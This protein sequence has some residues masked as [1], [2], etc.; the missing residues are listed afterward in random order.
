M[1]VVPV[2][3]GRGR[4]MFE[5]VAPPLIMRL[6]RSRVFPQGKVFLAYQPAG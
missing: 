4:T 6:A 2:V 5:G 1:V 3:L